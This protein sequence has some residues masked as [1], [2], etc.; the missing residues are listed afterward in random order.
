MIWKGKRR[1]SR[2]KASQAAVRWLI[3]PVASCRSSQTY[4]TRAE[5]LHLLARPG[6]PRG[7]LGMSP[8]GQLARTAWG[9]CRQTWRGRRCSP[10]PVFAGLPLFISCFV[11][12]FCVF[13]FVV[14][15]FL[16]FFC[17]VLFF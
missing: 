12:L 8:S 7:R 9:T 6:V 4:H 2:A 1:P 15:F 13:L 5:E 3:A 16:L 10:R 11:C 14:F 17:C